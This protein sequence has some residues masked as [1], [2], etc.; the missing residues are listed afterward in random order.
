[1]ADKFSGHVTQLYGPAENQ[2]LI[3]PND[4]ADLPQVTRWIYVNTPGTARYTL[5]GD[6][7]PVTHNVVAGQ[8]IPDRVKRVFATGTTAELIGKF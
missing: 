1:M 6:E 3:T 7:T 5:V 4:S 8:L 2:F